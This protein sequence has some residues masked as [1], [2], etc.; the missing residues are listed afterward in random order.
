MA[1]SCSLKA[2]IALAGDPTIRL[3]GSKLLPSVTNAPAPTMH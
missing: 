1:T 2:R 3:R